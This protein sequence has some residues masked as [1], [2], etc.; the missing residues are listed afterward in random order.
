MSMFREILRQTNERLRL[1]Q[2]AKSRIILEMA[3]D[4]DELFLFYRK[5]G[6]GEDD[7]MRASVDKLGVSDETLVQLT[8]IHES[9]LQRLL[10]GL[11]SQARSDPAVG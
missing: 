6:L 11:S 8:H 10:D 2:P 7:A 1:P 5:Q 3:A 4:L 9:P